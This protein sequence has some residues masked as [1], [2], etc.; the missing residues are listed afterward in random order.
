MEAIHHSVRQKVLA[1]VTQTVAQC[2][3]LIVTAV[4][5]FTSVHI[6]LS[7]VTLSTVHGT[8]PIPVNS[9]TEPMSLTY[10]F[11]LKIIIFKSFAKCNI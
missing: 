11:E 1:L 4:E 2:M 8:N 9:F 10:Y 6:D 5:H 3:I 7:N